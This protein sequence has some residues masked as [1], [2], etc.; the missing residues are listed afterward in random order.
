[1]SIPL[2][3]NPPTLDS[4]H[5]GVTSGQPSSAP[6]ALL[7]M[8]PPRKQKCNPLLLFK[9][10]LLFWCVLMCCVFDVFVLFL[11]ISWWTWCVFIKVCGLG[12]YCT[13]FSTTLISWEITAQ[14]LLE[15]MLLVKRWFHGS[16]WTNKIA[17]R[18]QCTSSW[19]MSKI[20]GFG[21]LSMTSQGEKV[22]GARHKH[23]RF[24]LQQAA[25]ADLPAAWSASEPQ[26]KQPAE[27]PLESMASIPEIYPKLREALEQFLHDQAEVESKSGESW[28]SQKLQQ[29]RQRKRGRSPTKTPTKKTCQRTQW[30]DHC[31]V[32]KNMRK[33]ITI[34]DIHINKKAKTVSLSTL[35]QMC[36]SCT[37][38]RGY[39]L[40]LS[41]RPLRSACPE[42]LQEQNTYHISST[43][44]QKTLQKW[45]YTGS[46]K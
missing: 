2:P 26:K 18:I 32:L 13:M 7:P 22:F 36:R 20:V 16:P 41:Q 15:E 46:Q 39:H 33:W 42:G 23:L 27:E 10:C 43:L 25:C 38:A 12:D 21:I 45:T 19:P 35:T 8:D 4:L 28:T 3:I 17:T 40:C 29:T 5:Q 44:M 14:T 1:M 30:F 37:W 9:W 6:V 11:D 24:L 31:I 34:H